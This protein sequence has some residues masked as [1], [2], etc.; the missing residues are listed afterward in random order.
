VES[1]RAVLH[2]FSVG[3]KKRAEMQADVKD[4]VATQ[5]ASLEQPAQVI[6]VSSERIASCDSRCKS[7]HLRGLQRVSYIDDAI[8]SV[9]Q[10][11]DI[12]S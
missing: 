3:I 9:K 8:R 6:C 12:L 10:R 2:E 11:I 5:A 7:C 1:K 4:G